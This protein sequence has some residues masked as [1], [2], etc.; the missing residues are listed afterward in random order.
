MFPTTAAAAVG[1]GGGS[2][3]AVVSTFE[4]GNVRASMFVILKRTV[5][6]HCNVD[7]A[8]CACFTAL[9]VDVDICKY[10]YTET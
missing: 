7:V 5:Y 1:G 10:Q 2:G 4:R 8:V 6:V 3:G 9:C